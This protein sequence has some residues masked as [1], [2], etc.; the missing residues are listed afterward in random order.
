MSDGCESTSWQVSQMDKDTGKVCDPNEPFQK[1][2]EPLSKTL[3]QYHND[4]VDVDE[5][6]EAWYS[7]LDTGK[8]FYREVDDKTLILGI[9]L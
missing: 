6:A 4:R 1:F 2:Y 5:R 3:I 8:E 7:F 9:I